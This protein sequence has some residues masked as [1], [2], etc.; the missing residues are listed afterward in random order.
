MVFRQRDVRPAFV[1][2]RVKLAI[3]AYFRLVAQTEGIHLEA[4]EDG[5][6]LGVGELGALDARRAGGAFYSS[7]LPKRFESFG[8]NFLESAPAPLELV[9]LADELN[10]LA[11]LLAV[12]VGKVV[13]GSLVVSCH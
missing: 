9:Q 11:R 2:E 7:D 5:G 4:A 3:P 10:C 8:L 6:N 1:N 13:F 12:E